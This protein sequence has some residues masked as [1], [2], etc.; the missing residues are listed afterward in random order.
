M[1]PHQ[2]SMKLWALCGFLQL[3]LSYGLMQEG[4]RSRCGGEIFREETMHHP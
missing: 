2:G 1:R 4:E 3:P